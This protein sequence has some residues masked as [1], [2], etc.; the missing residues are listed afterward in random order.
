MADN[1]QPS[2]EETA[3]IYSFALQNILEYG[4]MTI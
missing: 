1:W 3:L 2:K 4:C